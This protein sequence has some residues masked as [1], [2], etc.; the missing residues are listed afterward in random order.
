MDRT[1]IKLIRIYDGSRTAKEVITDAIMS[2]V[3][4]KLDSDI[5]IIKRK[6]YNL[7]NTQNIFSSMMERTSSEIEELKEQMAEWESELEKDVD[8][9]NAK[10]WVDLIKDYADIT[11]L[12]A[13]TLNRLVRRIV[14]HEEILEDGTRDIS[15]EIH[16][17]FRPTDDSKTYNLNDYAEEHSV[18]KAI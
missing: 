12:D 13:Q 15:L 16:Y 4:K 18:P 6:E 14:V 10:K 9:G 2:K 1:K 3:R 8:T 17:N 5:E 7:D 11:E